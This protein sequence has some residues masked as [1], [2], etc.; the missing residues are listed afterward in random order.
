MESKMTRQFRLA[1]ALRPSLASRSRKGLRPSR[2]NAGAVRAMSLIPA[3]KSILFQ[4]LPT[5][6]IATKPALSAEAAGLYQLRIF[7]TWTGGKYG[8]VFNVTYGNPECDSARVLKARGITGRVTM[9]DGASG[10]PRTVINIEAA[11]QL[12]CSEEDRDGLR[13]RK[14]GRRRPQ[15]RR[16]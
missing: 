5:K 14:P 6:K 2:I 16:A 15:P 8:Y 4:D 9:Y 3:K 13:F 7:P 12:D 11:A 10:A 1:G